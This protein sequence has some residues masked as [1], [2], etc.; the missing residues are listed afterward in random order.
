MNARRQY[1]QELGKEYGRA[2]AAGRGR[3]LDESAPSPADSRL[4]PLFGNLKACRRRLIIGVPRV[5]K[6]ICACPAG[7]SQS[8]RL[9]LCEDR[10]FAAHYGRLSHTRGLDGRARATS[11]TG[12]RLPE[13][14]VHL[15]ATLA[16]REV[17]FQLPTLSVS[18]RVA[19]P[20]P[21]LN[22]PDAAVSQRSA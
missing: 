3:L 5:S 15:F 11:L 14:I 16:A 10:T 13:S 6:V 12:V 2:D 7:A 9:R 21:N 19:S 8:W 18:L 4:G 22:Q 20:W 1:L 17:Q